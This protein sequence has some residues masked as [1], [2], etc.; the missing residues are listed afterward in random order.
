MA[1]M[2]MMVMMAVMFLFVLL[3]SM[4]LMKIGTNDSQTCLVP[5]QG[6]AHGNPTKTCTTGSTVI[7]R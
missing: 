3:I 1:M 5:A 2:M 6:I 4:M 7:G